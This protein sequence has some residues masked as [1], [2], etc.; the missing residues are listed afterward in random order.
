[1]KFLAVVI[2]FS[3]LFASIGSAQESSLNARPWSVLSSISIGQ[4]LQLDTKD[5]RSIKGKLDR[6][7]DSSLEMTVKGKSFICHS[8]DIKRIYVLRGRP[9]A[10]RTLI[11]AVVGGG[12]GA[13]I[14]AVITRNDD[15]FGPAFGAAVLGGVGLVIGSV[16]GLGFGLRQKKDLVYEAAS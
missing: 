12:G 14:G 13:V 3:L 7:T 2:I 1:M 4:N 15:W 11:G 5:G 6:I 10:R 8:G 9:V 16:I